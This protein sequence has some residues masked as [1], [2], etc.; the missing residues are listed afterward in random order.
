MKMTHVSD[1]Q[2]CVVEQSPVSSK[3]KK[4]VSIYSPVSMDEWV[5]VSMYP[6]NYCFKEGVETGDVSDDFQQLLLFERSEVVT[7]EHTSNFS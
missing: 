4:N 5:Y 6:I 2:E 7:Q 3:G 1:I